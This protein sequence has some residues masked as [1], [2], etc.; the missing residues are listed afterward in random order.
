[1]KSHHHQGFGQVGA[2]LREAAWAD[3]GT[4]EAVED[5]SKR[6][7]LGVLWH[8]EEAEDEALF[9]GLVEEA[10]AYRKHR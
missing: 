2:D 1:V 6:F 8:P 10:A 4:L 5:P 9:R 7:A 3:D